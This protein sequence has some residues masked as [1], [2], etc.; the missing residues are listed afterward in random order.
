MA[1]VDAVSHVIFGATL[2]DRRPPLH[3]DLIVGAP[4]LNRPVVTLQVVKLAGDE[5]VS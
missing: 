2:G 5:N 3:P 1:N 4:G